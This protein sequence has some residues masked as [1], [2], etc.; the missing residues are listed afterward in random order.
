[1]Q[2]PRMSSGAFQLVR[3]DGVPMRVQ[4]GPDDAVGAPR[5]ADEEAEGADV[6]EVVTIATARPRAP[7]GLVQPVEA[8]ADARRCMSERARGARCDAPPIKGTPVAREGTGRDAQAGRDRRRWSRQCTRHR[9]GVGRA[10]D[11]DGGRHDEALR[12]R[13]SFTLGVGARRRAP[14]R[15]GAGDARGGARAMGPGVGGLGRVPDQRRRAR[16]AGAP[17]GPALVDLSA[18]QRRPPT[19]PATSSTRN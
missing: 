11:P 4:Q 8:V 17:P 10:R 12:H 19:S 15:G 5:I 16:R 9:A 6:V 3:D 1:V 18:S 7:D 2:P 13:A 14:R